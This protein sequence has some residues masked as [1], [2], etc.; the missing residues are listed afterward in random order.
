[1]QKLKMT[2]AVAALGFAVIAG[3]GATTKAAPLSTEPLSSIQLADQMNGGIQNIQS[4]R[5]QHWRW[6]CADSWGWRTSRFRSC[7]RR[8]GC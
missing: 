5:C 6:R 4:R 8:R 1:M 2:C 7:L 3:S